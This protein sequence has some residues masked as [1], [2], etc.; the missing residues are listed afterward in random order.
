MDC[1]YRLVIPI[2]NYCG[3]VIQLTKLK[4]R[5]EAMPF[6]WHI[7][8]LPI[9]THHIQNDFS[10][11]F[12]LIPHKLKDEPPNNLIYKWKNYTNVWAGII[13]YDMTNDSVKET[14]Q[15]RIDRWEKTLSKFN[16]PICFVHET[17]NYN[18][19]DI[20]NFVNTIQSKYPKLIFHTVIIHDID[21]TN[22]T[23]Y[24]GEY[25]E[26][27]LESRFYTVYKLH[28]HKLR[29]ATGAD[30]IKEPVNEFWQKIFQ[31]YKFDIDQK[32][33]KSIEFA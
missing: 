15:R 4:L 24:D 1:T 30:Y 25:I 20:H 9:V 14:I 17:F 29:Q 27:S 2:G 13:H 12:D 31:N 10:D 8:N 28:Q 19:K 21:D 26:K 22:V 7:V 33:V 6:D 3:T 5:N 18:E 23:T 32:S 11:F 16:D